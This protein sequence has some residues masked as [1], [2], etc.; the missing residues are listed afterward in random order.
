MYLSLFLSTCLRFQLWPHDIVVLLTSQKKKKNKNEFQ[1]KEN[2][3]VEDDA[4]ATCIYIWKDEM[5]LLILLY[6]I[7]KCLLQFA[8]ST[9]Y[10][11]YNSV[12]DHLIITGACNCRKQKTAKGHEEC[13]VKVQLTLI[14]SVLV[15][16]EGSDEPRKFVVLHLS[17]PADCAEECTSLDHPSQGIVA[18]ALGSY[19]CSKIEV[20]L[21]NHHLASTRGQ[22][23]L[24]SRDVQVRPCLWG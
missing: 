23:S 7:P 11:V 18:W 13:R 1:C 16:I 9:C 24:R 8:K 15:W 21:E 4:N 22:D 3:P 5:N 10:I 2:L 14:Y 19:W 6:I 12:I 20:C 17:T